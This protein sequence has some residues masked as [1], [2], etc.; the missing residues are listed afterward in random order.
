MEIDTFISMCF[1][2]DGSYNKEVNYLA[3]AGKNCKNCKY[4][5]YAERED[6]CPAANR[7]K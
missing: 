2:S 6:L 1:N 3:I 5:E 7:I 4:C